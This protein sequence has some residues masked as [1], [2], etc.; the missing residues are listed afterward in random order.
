MSVIFAYGSETGMGASIIEEAYAVAAE[1]LDEV[2]MA[3]P[4]ELDSLVSNNLSCSTLLVIC[5]SSTGQG[6]LPKNARKF[7]AECHQLSGV[8]Y[9]MLCLGDSNYA[10]F[11]GG[12]RALFDAFNTAGAIMTHPAIFA[13]DNDKDAFADQTDQF[14]ETCSSLIQAW[15][16][17]SAPGLSG[18]LDFCLPLTQR[19]MRKNEAEVAYSKV[20]EFISINHV[21][22][23]SLKIPKLPSPPFDLAVVTETTTHV[24]AY[25]NFKHIQ[26][27]DIFDPIN[28]AEPNLA[29]VAQSRKLTGSGATKTCWE[30]TLRIDGGGVSTSIVRILSS[31]SYCYDFR[32]SSF[33]NPASIVSLTVPFTV[34]IVLRFSRQITL[35]KLS[36][37]WRH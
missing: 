37:A 30:V 10:S 3:L 17:K 9:F 21:K 14:I 4:V 27:G 7:V 29:Q 15:L 16:D 18:P 8:P 24:E 36:V 5:C 32:F 2:E 6:E 28:S 13:D 31:I 26:N 23:D 34:A 19:Q 1:T 12:P 20:I 11:M 25:T 33:A 35:P 22:A